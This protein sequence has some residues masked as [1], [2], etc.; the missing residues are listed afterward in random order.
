MSVLS[1]C[2]QVWRSS[3]DH[4]HSPRHHTLNVDQQTLHQPELQRKEHAPHPIPRR[5]PRNIRPIAVEL[6]MRFL[7]AIIQGRPRTARPPTQQGTPAQDHPTHPQQSA[8][9]PSSYLFAPFNGHH[10][11]EHHAKQDTHHNHAPLAA[12]TNELISLCLFYVR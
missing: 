12:E 2:F 3:R 4:Y 1:H 7:F 5:R 6:L 9:L 10:E 8:E 11:R